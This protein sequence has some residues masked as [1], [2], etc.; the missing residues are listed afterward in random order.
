[1]RALIQ[2]VLHAAVSVDGEVKGSVEQGFLVLLGVKVGD[3]EKEAQ[4][5]AKKVA[6]LR[7]FT[8]SED[9]M[10]LSLLDIGG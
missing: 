5:L 4:F 7:V 2:R 10:N 8:D 9:K 1:M 6:E 3:T